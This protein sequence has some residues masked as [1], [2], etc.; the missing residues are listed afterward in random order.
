MS[1][2]NQKSENIL[3]ALESKKG[4]LAAIVKGSWEGTKREGMGP[5][6]HFCAFQLSL[7]MVIQKDT[8]MAFNITLGMLAAHL[9]PLLTEEE[10][11]ALR[12][13]RTN[14]EK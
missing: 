2:E 13:E 1:T 5:A 12:N 11:A 3:A 4:S 7:M 8:A 10:K 14:L 9:L 6:A